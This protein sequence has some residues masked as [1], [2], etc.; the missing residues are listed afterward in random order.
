MAFPAAP[1]PKLTTEHDVAR[2]VMR[3]PGGGAVRTEMATHAFGGHVERYD[4][5]V[6]LR[7]IGLANEVYVVLPATE[8]HVRASLA[9][10]RRAATEYSLHDTRGPR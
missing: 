1:T 9:I 10:L 8:E 3:L 2:V 7:V 4:N 5:L 6:R